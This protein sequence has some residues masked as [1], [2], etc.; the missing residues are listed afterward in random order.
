M[1][2]ERGD[3]IFDELGF[4]CKADASK[5]VIEEEQ[6]TLLLCLCLQSEMAA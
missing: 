1:L 3:G 5:Y 6:T 2:T 4:D